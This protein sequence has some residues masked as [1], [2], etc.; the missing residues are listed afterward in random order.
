[1]RAEQA[2]LGNLGGTGCKTWQIYQR[3]YGAG[4]DVLLANREGQSWRDVDEICRRIGAGTRPAID[5]VLKWQTVHRGY[6][7]LRRGGKI[8]GGLLRVNADVGPQH[9]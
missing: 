5:I 9:K 8:F 4:N 7:V 1:M 3:G 6:G 2:L